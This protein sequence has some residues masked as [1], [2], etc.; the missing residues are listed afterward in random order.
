MCLRAARVSGNNDPGSN[1]PQFWIWGCQAVHTV[2]SRDVLIY[3]G[4]KSHPPRIWGNLGTQNCP[5]PTGGEGGGYW[6]ANPPPQP[7][8]KAAHKTRASD[9]FSENSIVLAFNSVPARWV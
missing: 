8:T 4:G 1:C 2:Q 9:Q 5:T 6:T 3:G 7:A